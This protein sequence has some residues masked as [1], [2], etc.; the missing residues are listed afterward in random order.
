MTLPTTRKTLAFLVKLSLKLSRTKKSKH[1]LFYF[2]ASPI[3]CVFI[4]IFYRQS[5]IMF[6][7]LF[8][9]CYSFRCSDVVSFVL[10]VKN[11]LFSYTHY[12]VCV[13]VV[14]DASTSC[15]AGYHCLLSALH[16]GNCDDPEMRFYLYRSRSA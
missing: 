9:N 10:M 4:S 5:A 7:I 6:S 2:S 8:G 15:P 14:D 1:V 13:H 16:L 12:S 3:S 11:I